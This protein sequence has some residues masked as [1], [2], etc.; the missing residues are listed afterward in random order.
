MTSDNS[1]NLEK[2]S[3]GNTPESSPTLPALSEE[4]RLLAQV[5]ASVYPSVK[6]DSGAGWSKE[7]IMDDALNL[8][9]RIIREARKRN[10]NI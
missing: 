4:T 3:P 5:T 9:E 7:I 6:A 1:I 10:N 2:S 8:G